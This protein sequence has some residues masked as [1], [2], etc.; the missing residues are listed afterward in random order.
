[1]IYKKSYSINLILLTIL[2]GFL[3]FFRLGQTTLTNWDEAWFASV[4][5]DM[6]AGN[7]WLNPMWNGE[8]WFYEPPLVSWVLAAAVKIFGPSEFWLRLFSALCALIIIW[9]TYLL[10]SRLA[11][12][13]LA[14][15]FSSLI[16]LSNIEFLFRGRQI[17]VD[18]P[19]TCLLLVAFYSSIR[20][21]DKKKISWLF[22]ASTTLALA[23]LTKR[24]SAALALPAITFVLF[25]AARKYRKRGLYIGL[26]AFLLVVI[27]WHL[28][29]FLMWQRVF[30]DKYFLGYTLDKVI[31]VN[32]GAG[33]SWLFYVASLKRA[34][35]FWFLLL[36][37]AGIWFTHTV[38]VS[39]NKQ[40]AAI[41]IYGLTFF[42][43]LSLVPI[44]SSW[45]LLPAYPIFAIIVGLFVASIASL[46]KRLMLFSVV[47]LFCIFLFQI[48]YW[49]KSFIVPETTRHQSV[50]A[51]K[52]NE[53]TSP[54]EVLYLDDDY[55][56]V[57]VYY[58][59][60][61]VIPLRFNRERLPAEWKIN[62]APGSY[63][64]TNQ[65]NFDSLVQR[66][67]SA[68]IPIGRSRDLLLIMA[69]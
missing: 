5:Q 17:N 50:I 34:F 67:S 6:V 52:V 14:G 36:P 16:L 13:T 40:Y 62:L 64:L 56:P 54:S 63:L 8:P 23:F 55:L 58:S 39:R 41:A 32:P 12:N 48:M 10:A 22:V 43:F 49:R 2:A 21:V 33:T 28:G 31:S 65:Q 18:I 26:S 7:R 24:A 51:R 38:S 35:K 59:K 30:L 46:S 3:L 47:G 69:R 60:R 42:A 61:K 29:S 20:W 9:V 15:L 45:F 44:K 27:P 53:I 25:Q 11:K 66:S 19:L 1:M 68:F 4:S 57:A 37:F